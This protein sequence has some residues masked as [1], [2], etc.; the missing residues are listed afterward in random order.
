MNPNSQTQKLKVTETCTF[1]SKTIKKGT[2]AIPHTKE[3][4]FEHV[5]CS[6]SRLGFIGDPG[7]LERSPSGVPRCHLCGWYQ[8]RLDVHIKEVHSL[9][10]HEYKEA[11]E[12]SESDLLISF[13]EED[14]RN[15]QEN[16]KPEDEPLKLFPDENLEKKTFAG[17]PSSKDVL[18]EFSRTRVIKNNRDKLSNRDMKR[19][20]PRNRKKPKIKKSFKELK[21]EGL[22]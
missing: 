9:L 14:S 13:A 2:K 8:D 3:K 18:A 19:Q 10:V 7:F 22:L 6:E 1:C 16:V 4:L 20:N 5:D 12:L 15:K 11:F 17:R 21:Q